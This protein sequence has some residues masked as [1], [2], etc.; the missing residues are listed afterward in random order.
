MFNQLPRAIRSISIPLSTAR[1]L[2]PHPG[3]AITSSPPSA[4]E[5]S[6]SHSLPLR[7]YGFPLLHPYRR[8]VQSIVTSPSEAQTSRCAPGAGRITYS[9]MAQAGGSYS[10]PLKKFKYVPERKPPL[11]EGRGHWVLTSHCQ[12]RLP[13][14]TK[15][16]EPPLGPRRFPPGFLT[17]CAVG[18]T[19]LITRF[20]YD[21][22]DNMYQATIGIDFLSKARRQP[23]SSST[24]QGSNTMGADYVS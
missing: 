15:R 13:R 7:P 4:S 22:F 24:P 19:S 21:S 17:A 2:G 3:S 11:G 6:A 20:M 10:A 23:N 16:Y 9:T 1:H 8:D 14:R 12:A 18:K 5:Y